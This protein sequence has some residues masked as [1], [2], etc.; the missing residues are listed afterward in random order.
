MSE[1]ARAFL[2]GFHR[3]YPLR[4]GAPKEELRSRLRVQSNVFGLVLPVLQQQGVL[5]EEGPVVRLPDHA[6][7][8][9]EEQRRTADA[10]V[11]LLR[12]SPYSPPTDSP[13]DPEV[14]S[15]LIDEGKVVKVSENVVFSTSAYQEMV[16][17]VREYAREKG[18]ITAADVRDM[19]GASRKYAI[20]LL[21]YLDQQ[22]VTRRVGDARVLR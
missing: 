15:V 2:K 6:P 11:D 17:K 3:Q 14:L 4:K 20:A 7:Q 5:A 21:D 19:F 18:E 9:T 22:R 10:Y 16:E 13:V 12:S 8:L 1:Q